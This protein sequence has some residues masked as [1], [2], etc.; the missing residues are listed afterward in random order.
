MIVNRENSDGIAIAINKAGS[1]VGSIG[2]ISSD[3]YIAEG[4]SGLRFDGENNQILPSSTTASTDGTCNLGA[5]TARF[6]DLY[7]SGII[8]KGTGGELDLRSDGGGFAYKQNL[9]LATAG[10]TFTGQSTRGDVAAIRLYQ[11]ATGADGGYI[12]FDTCNS[13]STTLTEKARILSD[14]SFLIGETSQG[15]STRFK[16]QGP[17]D[18]STGF[19]TSFISMGNSGG[20]YPYIGYNCGPTSTGLTYFR[21][22][23]DYASWID[24]NA[25][26]VRTFTN[27]GGTGNT[28]GSAGPYVAVGGTSWTSS[29]DRRL[30]DDIQ[31]ISY[32]LDTVKALEPVSYVRNDRDV[33]SRELGFIA[34]DVEGVVEEVVSVTDDGYY[35]LDYQRLIPVLTKAIQEQQA[36]IEALT[37]RIEALES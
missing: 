15:L 35:G 19:N 10:V 28:T 5:G 26:Q 18:A 20:G 16:I 30:K 24:F 25:G 7:L 32:G 14:G 21:Y 33:E 3:L 31:E 11:T 13:G 2:S 29:S 6:K 8:A 27:S 17:N 1:T 12:R 34:Q 22:V 9:D 36:T 23:N 4:N 37:A